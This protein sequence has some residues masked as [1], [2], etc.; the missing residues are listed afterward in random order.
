[1]QITINVSGTDN[2]S[3][4]ACYDVLGKVLEL[5]QPH[6]FHDNENERDATITCGPITA[7]VSVRR[8]P[9]ANT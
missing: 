3:P 4:G 8:P 9:D 2:M 6:T 5:A 7:T 1:M